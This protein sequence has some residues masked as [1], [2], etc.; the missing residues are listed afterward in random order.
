MPQDLQLC[1]RDCRSLG[2]Q[3]SQK[4]RVSHM[5]AMRVRHES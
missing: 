2:Q 4:A 5:D 3:K 1:G